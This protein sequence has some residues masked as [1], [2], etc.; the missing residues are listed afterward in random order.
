L[1]I[2]GFT[3]E[4]L[5]FPFLAAAFAGFIDVLAGGG[6]LI[7]LPALILSGVPPLAALGTNK[8]QGSMGTGTATFMMLKKKMVSWHNVK[9]LMLYAFAGSALGT[10]AIQFLNVQILTFVI[11]AALLFISIY[12]LVAPKSLEKTTEPRLSKNTYKKLIIPSIGFYD[13]MFGPGAGSFFSLAG[14]SMRGHGI[15]NSTAIAKTL[16]FS[17]NIASLIIFLIAGHVVWKIGLL[18]MSGQLVGA[19]LG[20]HC[21]IRINPGYLRL[22]VVVMCLGMLTKYVI[23]MGWLSGFSA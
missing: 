2:G 4:L 7:T 3:A 6:G 15:I 18:M 11:P 20:A 21:L 9:P 22:I 5:V 8:L 16:N 23:T 12:F 13:G 19:W 10:V 14:V 1:D 17:T